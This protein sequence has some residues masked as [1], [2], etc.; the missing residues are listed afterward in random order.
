MPALNPS[1]RCPLTPGEVLAGGCLRWTPLARR[2]AEAWMPAFLTLATLFVAWQVAVSRA[3]ACT[4]AP[5][6][7]PH[8]VLLREL[9]RA[10]DEQTL[11]APQRRPAL[12]ALGDKDGAYHAGR[13]PVVLVHGLAG[14]P[15]D[16]APLAAPF[17]QAGYQV[18][19]LFFDD[20]GRLAREN[21]QGLADELT[22]LARQHLRRGQRLMLVAHSA[23]GL[24]ARLAINLLSASGDLPRFGAVDLVA[25]DTPWHG[26]HGPSDATRLGRL[27]MAMVQPFMP[28]GMED[29]RAESVLF[30]GDPT[31]PNPA[32]SRGLLRYPL[33]SQ[34]RVHLCFAQAG[35]QVHDYTEGLLVQL[36]DQ[37]ARYYQHSQ[38]V[39]GDARLQNFWQ[40]LISADAYFAFQEELR[41]LADRGGLSAEHVHAALLEHFPRYPG[42][43]VSILQRIVEPGQPTLLSQLLPAGRD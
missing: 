40:A 28:D 38:P 43:H 29:L 8:A 6:R 11:L 25:I 20:L 19:A 30:A 27:R 12:Y 7:A 35:D 1:S 15:A 14:H 5:A 41:T 26:Y 36:G 34:V 3:Q 39:R 4:L 31:S 21:G 23:G 9:S 32:L 17:S 37:I 13:P 10:C 22:R 16:L 24:I 18:Y 2:R 42:D 33:P